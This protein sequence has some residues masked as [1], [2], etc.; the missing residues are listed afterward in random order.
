[1]FFSCKVVELINILNFSTFWNTLQLN[2]ELICNP[3]TD[4]G[5]WLFMYSGYYFII[6]LYYII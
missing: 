2:L 1:M 6:I 5:I 3:A 4:F